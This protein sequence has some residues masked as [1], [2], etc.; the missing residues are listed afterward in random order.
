MRPGKQEWA[1]EQD[2]FRSRLN[3]IINMRHEL[4][5]L[6]AAVD[7][8]WIDAELAGAV[9]ENGQ[10]AVPTR[11]KIG[12]LLLKHIF[13]LSDEGVCE[14]W[15]CDPYFQHF[16]GE[17]SFQHA[18]PHARSNLSRS[19]G[20]IGDKLDRL[21]AESLRV[22]HGSGALKTDDL[23]RVTVD[24][25][26]MPKAAAHP[27]DARLVLTAIENL[28]ELAN[29]TGVALRQSYVRL[30]KRACLMTGR[31]AHAKQWKRHRREIKFLRVRLG[32]LI[33][34]I[35]RK[36]ADDERLEEAVAEP[37]SKAVRTRL[38]DQHQRG[39]KL[40][41]WHAPEVE[42]IGKG[43]AR[44]P[45]E[46]G[47]KVSLVATNRRCKGGQF[48]LRANALPGAPYDGHTLKEVLAETAALT[49]RLIERAFVDKGYRGHDAQNP[50]RVFVS[51]KKRGVDGQIKRELRR[52]SAIEPVIGHLKSGGSMG[53][54]FLKG[55]HGDRANPILAATGHNLR[56]VLR[57]MKLLLRVL[58]AAILQQL[59]STANANVAS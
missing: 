2:L 38:Q 43:K 39:P 12:L 47:V 17:E 42:C 16:T 28:G 21:L 20:R 55:R 10:P 58:P 40:Y 5:R 27:T 41:S 9:S 13:D 36:I 53:R 3:Q 44:Q 32:R 26:V 35:R 54:N 46:F 4:V 49:G 48:V 7:W 30:A 52:R 34:G 14:R 59:R 50:M 19:R 6:G 29:E 18:F 51:G 57:R 23:A 11:F 24:S 37:I 22:A 31:D 25:T 45:Y 33:R 15:G 8:S 56:L 1:G